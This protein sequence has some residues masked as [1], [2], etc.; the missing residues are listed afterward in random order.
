[1]E[2]ARLQASAGCCTGGHATA[3]V[4]HVAA[5]NLAGSALSST[6]SPD[7][8]TLQLDLTALPEGLPP[9][10]DGAT[11]AEVEAWVEH[12]IDASAQPREVSHAR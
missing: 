2:G 8:L 6:P 7:P 5:L 4:R 11:E 12:F 10:R 3:G 9:L 1:L